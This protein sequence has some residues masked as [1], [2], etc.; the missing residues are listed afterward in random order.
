MP[1]LADSR[2]CRRNVA[3]S[4]SHLASGRDDAMIA[5]APIRLA[6]AGMLGLLCACSD[7]S[8]TLDRRMSQI[9]LEHCEPLPAAQRLACLRKIDAIEDD[10]QQKLDQA[11]REQAVRQS[12]DEVR[13]AILPGAQGW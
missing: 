12:V 4:G 7:S 13:D 9:R 5:A 8:A 6:V 11:R 3:A 1:T 10:A 2:L